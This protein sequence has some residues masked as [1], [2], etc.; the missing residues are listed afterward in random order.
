MAM[1]SGGCAVTQRQDTPVDYTFEKDP[2]TG[3]SF[4]LYVPSGYDQSRPAPV[5]VT[6]HGTPP[7]DVANHHIR[8][9]KYLGEKH[10]CIIVAPELIGTDGLLGNGPVIGM[11]NNERYILSI[12]SLLSYRYNVD[13]ANVMITGFSGGGFPTYWVGLRHP[14]V[15]SAAVSR[16]GNFNQGNLEGWYPPAAAEI[17]I[18]VYWGSNDPGT[19]QSQC[20][21]AVRYLKAKG[22]Q[23]ESEELPGA[24]HERKPEVAMKFFREN[25]NEPEGTMRPLED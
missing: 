4:Y 5:V 22:F 6:C 23:V 11:L 3:R 16:N 25:W 7:Y 19:I 21:A 2:V 15:F 14:D 17:P 10:G 9:W 18:K 13:R 20:E 24:G 1:V 8:E 12:L